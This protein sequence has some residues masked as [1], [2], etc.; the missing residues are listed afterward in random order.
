MNLISSSLAV[1][2]YVYLVHGAIYERFEDVPRE[3]GFDFVIVGGE[4]ILI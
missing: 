3:A 2:T 4:I 1:L